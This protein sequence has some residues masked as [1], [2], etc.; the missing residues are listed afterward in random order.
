MGKRLLL[1]T[2]RF[3][4]IDEKIIERLEV[5]GF[6]VE[7][8]ENRNLIFDYHGTKSKLKFIRRIYSL[9]FSPQKRNIKN[10]LRKIENLKFDIL[11]AI[12]GH[13]ICSYLFRRLKRINSEIYSVLYLWDSFNMYSWNKEIKYFDKV[14]TFDHSDSKMYGIEYKPNFHIKNANNYKDNKYDVFFVGK[15]SQ[16]RLKQIDIILYQLKESSLKYFVKLWPAYSVILHNRLIYKA[17]KTKNLN[18]IWINNYIANF[19]AV[20]GLLNRDFILKNSLSYE[21]VY[22]KMLSSN[23]VLDLPFQEQQGF[24]HGLIQALANGKKVITTNQKI[25]EEVFFNHVQIQILNDKN[26][27]IDFDWIKRESNFPTHKYFLNL[28]LTEWLKSILNVELG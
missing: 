23:V 20:E 21:E 5:L 6:D 15:F 24:S 16:F 18:Q 4:G 10:E 27:E 12:N 8:F 11:F 14:Y 2:P 26:P 9:L 1:I 17:L 22:D 19:E 25:K 13:A 28:E 7:W 3:Y